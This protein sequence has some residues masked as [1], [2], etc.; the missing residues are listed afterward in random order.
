MSMRGYKPPVDLSVVTI[1][2]LK[3]SKAI[4]EKLLPPLKATPA[5]IIN[6]RSY[7]ILDIKNKLQPIHEY[8][9]G[10]IVECR[11]H[12]DRRYT[13]VIVH[14]GDAEVVLINLKDG[15]VWE[16]HCGTTMNSSG[17]ISGAD[18]LFGNLNV[19]NVWSNI[20][21]WLNQT[22]GFSCS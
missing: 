21:D 20:K 4:I 19:T 9:V 16:P 22:N 12:A 18:L 8:K 13:F 15:N 3:Y 5:V 6:G 7:S 10:N 17:V 1:D 2:G 11:T 14:S